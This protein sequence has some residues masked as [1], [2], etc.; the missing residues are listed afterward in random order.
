MTNP[1]MTSAATS[2]EGDCL[3]E[4]IGNN[5]HSQ[6]EPAIEDS[7]RHVQHNAPT[8][9]QWQEYLWEI[10]QAAE[11]EAATTPEDDA[12][13]LATSISSTAAR[14][15]RRQ[16]AATRAAME[17]MEPGSVPPTPRPEAPNVTETPPLPL[18]M[19]EAVS[20]TREVKAGQPPSRYLLGVLFCP[21][22]HSYTLT[23][24]VDTVE[25]RTFEFHSITD[26]P[27]AAAP[28]AELRIRTTA[29]VHEIRQLLAELYLDTGMR[30]P[31]MLRPGTM[32]ILPCL[33]SARQVMALA[34]G[35]DATS[36]PVDTIIHIKD[37]TSKM[38]QRPAK[39]LCCESCRQVCPASEWNG[40]HCHRGWDI[41]ARAVKPEPQQPAP[42]WQI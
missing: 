28:I 11:I 4:H 31:F 1:E 12:S 16:R 30:Q 37:D 9:E 35:V 29:R 14:H 23:P 10:T 41:Q 38:V 20:I 17:P 25:W 2:P 36:T 13:G 24:P 7:P 19:L 40:S 18:D 42:V 26:N 39:D 34:R 8:P 27:R 15:Y 22:G 32:E 5:T 21:G 6:E 33:L 3:M